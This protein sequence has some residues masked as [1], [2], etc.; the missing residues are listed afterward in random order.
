MTCVS[1]HCVYFFSPLYFA[2]LILILLTL[3]VTETESAFIYSSNTLSKAL[4][5]A[6]LKTRMDTLHS[7]LHSSTKLSSLGYENEHENEQIYDRHTLAQTLLRR[8]DE[9]PGMTDYEIVHDQ[10]TGVSESFVVKSIIWRASFKG[11]SSEKFFC[12]VLHKNAKVDRSKLSDFLTKNMILNLS[13][14]QID[15]KD[16]SISIPKKVIIEL[17]DPTKAELVSGYPIGA[18]P[19][20]GHAIKDMP[21]ILDDTMLDSGEE[22]SSINKYYFGGCGIL[23]IRG[24]DDSYSLRFSIEQMKQLENVLVGPVSRRYS[25]HKEYSMLESS[26]SE[27]KSTQLGL[28]SFKINAEND[29]NQTV[30]EKLWTAASKRGGFKTVQNIFKNLEAGKCSTEDFNKLIWKRASGFK[31]CSSG[32][33]ILHRGKHIIFGL[34][35]TQNTY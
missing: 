9:I 6:L 24:K 26:Y 35:L 16:L 1:F 19:P 10:Q 4:K 15:R 3:S 27:M 29:N 17:A 22:N 8:L 23:P 21:I 20:L 25:K 30:V 32:K 31:G 18:I 33:N 2:A 7:H 28:K 5:E 34:N 14:D 13:E 12:T 11:Y